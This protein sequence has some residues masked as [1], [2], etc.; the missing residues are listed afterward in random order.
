MCICILVENAD[1]MAA[2][3]P[4]PI[5]NVI[6]RCVDVA[7]ELLRKVNIATIPPT[8]LYNPKSITPRISKTTREVY[9]CM[10]MMNIIRAYNKNVF[11]AI[12]LL[13]E[14]ISDTF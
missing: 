13:F 5:L 4:L 2:V 10:H 9:N 1:F 8:T 12:R 6:Y 11:F 3:S 7:I 14:D